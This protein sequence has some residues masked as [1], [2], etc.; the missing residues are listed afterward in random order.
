MDYTRIPKDF[1]PGNLPSAYGDNYNTTREVVGFDIDRT[2]LAKMKA[3]AGYSITNRPSADRALNTFISMEQSIKNIVSGQQPRQF[4]LGEVSPYKWNNA[5]PTGTA[6]IDGSPAVEITV[7][8]GEFPPVIPPPPP[9]P[10]TGITIEPTS[11]S[12][13]A[14][15]DPN[16][17]YL[18]ATVTPADATDKSV[19]WSNSDETRAVP[20]YSPDDPF[21]YMVTAAYNEETP[22]KYVTVSVT[23]NDGNYRAECV[24][25]VSNH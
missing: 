25:T 10:V 19:T 9:I 18:T 14:D 7:P 21:V 23:T 5:Q 3:A 4:D 15:G 17:A 20:T 24:I 8:N 22:Q 6:A 12:L 11:I 2:T 16:F 1:I 13:A